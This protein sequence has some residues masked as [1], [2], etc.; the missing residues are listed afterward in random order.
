MDDF[1]QRLR[2]Q[3]MRRVPEDW[4][5][6][7][8]LVCRGSKVE[9]RAQEPPRAASFLSTLLWP[10]PKAWAGLA[11]AWIVI[12][13]IHFSMGEPAPRTG[14]TKAAS[15]SPEMVAELKQQQ[16][17]FAELAGINDPQAADRPRFLPLPRSEKRTEVM[18]A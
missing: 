17:W 6:E 18:T 8:L 5:A 2:Q 12:V 16:R 1:E 11:T 4:R 3:P 9:G 10:H 15:P 7:I 14:A 13:A